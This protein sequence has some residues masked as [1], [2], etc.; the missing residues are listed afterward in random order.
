MYRSD[1]LLLGIAISYLCRVITVFSLV[2]LTENS[3][4]STSQPN[5][6]MSTWN[7]P[8]FLNAPIR[9][10]TCLLWHAIIALDLVKCIWGKE[11]QH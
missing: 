3:C 6:I 1:A 2:H 9:N 4:A 11:M 7:L 5:D 10:S 8:I